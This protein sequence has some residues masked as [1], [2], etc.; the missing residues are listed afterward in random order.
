MILRE[1]EKKRERE[2]V[3]GHPSLITRP[4]VDGNGEKSGRVQRVGGTADLKIAGLIFQRAGKKKKGWLEGSAFEGRSAS[5]R[6]KL[7]F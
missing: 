3:V 2:R 7:S 1:K 5:V 6:L 4:R